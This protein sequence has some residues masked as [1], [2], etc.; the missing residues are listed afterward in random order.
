MVRIADAFDR[1]D[2][3]SLVHGGERE[4][5]THA[6]SIDQE[7]ACAALTVI[8]PFLRSGE[9]QML[10]QRVEQRHACVEVEMRG[11]TV[12][13]E[14]DADRHDRRISPTRREGPMG[15]WPKHDAIGRTRLVIA[16]TAS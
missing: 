12:D 5:R 16:P 3:V 13:G 8:A 9:V 10:A 14:V 4:A 15:L 6:S 2:L 7:R 11:P 1:D